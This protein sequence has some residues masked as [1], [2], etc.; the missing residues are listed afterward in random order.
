MIQYKNLSK[1]YGLKIVL[2]NLN[3][4]I[5]RGEF[6]S[7]MG[8][9]GAGKTTLLNIT[10]MLI[11]PSGGDILFDG[12]SI[13]KNNINI[14]MKTGYLSHQSFL[15][16]H[17]T[18]VENLQFYGEL[19]NV[20]NLKVEIDRVLNLV[21]LYL[22][23]NEPVFTF[24]RGMI[25]R[26]SLARAMLH[27]PELYLLDE[28]FSG[29]DSDSV[30]GLYSILKSLIEE[31]CTIIMATHNND[32]AS[33]LSSKIWY[34]KKGKIIKEQICSFEKKLEL[35]KESIPMELNNE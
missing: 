2:N 3:K 27:R 13:K 29:L 32:H 8:P 9:N 24:S 26:L 19:Y 17:L 28:P 4:E 33:L 30:K 1:K 11:T 5:S 34:L 18:G 6:I 23:R 20:E 7:L 12:I 21:N 35:P 31:N 25:Q 22:V 14:R 10:A 16:D 15:Y